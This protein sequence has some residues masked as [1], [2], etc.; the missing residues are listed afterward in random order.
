MK[1][2]QPHRNL[3][4]E[5]R[6]PRNPRCERHVGTVPQ[7]YQSHCPKRAAPVVD[8]PWA[9]D[10]NQLYVIPPAVIKSNRGRFS[11]SGARDDARDGHLIAEV[12]RTDHGRLQPWF[13]DRPLTRQIRAK[14]SLLH[15]LT[16]QTVRCANRLRAVLQVFGQWTSQ[17]S[18]TF[19]QRGLTQNQDRFWPFCQRIL[20][21][22][23]EWRG[24]P[25]RCAAF[26]MTRN[27][28]FYPIIELP[29]PLHF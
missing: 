23:Y 12:L 7:V 16:K 8:F 22:D 25:L 24:S 3:A 10:Y 1:S 6:T 13:S 26:R 17:I 27:G 15:Y 5:L 21:F 14:V 20:P 18:L 2:C 9:W 29:N 11:S 28:A 19:I 4:W